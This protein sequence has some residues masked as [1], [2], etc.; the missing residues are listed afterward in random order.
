MEDLRDQYKQTRQLNDVRLKLNGSTYRKVRSEYSHTKMGNLISIKDQGK[1]E[2]LADLNQK[3]EI[4][5]PN[6]DYSLNK[7]KRWQIA[8]ELTENM[9]QFGKENIDVRLYE[10]RN[11]NEKKSNCIAIHKSKGDQI[12]VKKTY[13]NLESIKKKQEI[14]SDGDQDDAE[15][16]QYEI[17]Y[18]PKKDILK[19][20]A[21]KFSSKNNFTK[22]TIKN[23]NSK[24]NEE[25]D[26]LSEFSDTDDIA[27]NEI[28]Q[29]KVDLNV[30]ELINLQLCTMI[31]KSEH[32][33]K[34]K[35]RLF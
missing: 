6:L 12:H 25:I 30:D 3:Y 10:T 19:Y 4:N 7:K 28:V 17:E 18:A 11:R 20:G 5:K 31:E 8:T 2:N 35:G 34:I 21:K 9:S 27:S 29:K 14:N 13:A 32:K 16:V 15:Y 1:M 24:Y 26:D 33:N 23:F 22:N